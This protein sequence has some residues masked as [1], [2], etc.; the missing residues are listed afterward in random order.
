MKYIPEKIQTHEIKNETLESG[1]MSKKV[2]HVN[3]GAPA[4]TN[5]TGEGYEQ[6]SIWIDSSNGD[7]YICSDHSAEDAVWHNMEGDDVNVTQWVTG[8]TYGWVYGGY[9]GSPVDDFERLTFSSEG[10]T[11]DQGEMSTSFRLGYGGKSSTKL[12]SCGGVEN[13]PGSIVDTIHAS[14]Q[15]APFGTATDWGNLTTTLR[16]L[17]GSSNATYKFIHGG[18]VGP[19]TNV[20]TDIIQKFA[21][22]AAADATNVGELTVVSG[23][24]VGVTDSIGGYGYAIGGANTAGDKYDIIE[25][26]SLSSDENG[27]DVG[28]TSST[29]FHGGAAHNDLTNGFV[30][31]HSGGG[32]TIDKFAFGSP[33]SSSDVGETNIG[34]HF[35]GGHPD[36]SSTTTG[37]I[38]GGLN[39]AGEYYIDT[40]HKFS[41]TAPYPSADVGEITQE[42]GY[43]MGAAT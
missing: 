25:R 40:I 14:P 9:N 33:A 30:S 8:E 24:R 31:T 21:I 26:Y 7:M 42:Q 6:G 18:H 19:P 5:D 35:T 29:I 16:E 32:T 3:A 39:P 17:H 20:V 37:Y 43:S 1:D 36:P 28:E 11:A 23:D 22:A 27:T 15:A 12:F 10:N 41:F 38:M 4:K 34:P 13:T 2:I